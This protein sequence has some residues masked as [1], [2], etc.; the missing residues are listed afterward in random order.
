MCAGAWLGKADGDDCIACHALC[1]LCCETRGACPWGG[2]NVAHRCQPLPCPCLPFS[3]TLDLPR[4]QNIARH[5]SHYSWV[6][7][8][9]PSAVSWGGSGVGSPWCLGCKA[10]GVGGCKRRGGLWMMLPFDSG[11]PLHGNRR[12][13]HACGTLRWQRATYRRSPSSQ[14]DLHAGGEFAA[15]PSSPHT[16]NPALPSPGPW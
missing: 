7:S 10:V 12:C 8:L 6:A 5:R 3:A 14:R 13:R 1:A 15:T 11:C 4:L 2:K 16:P 9:G